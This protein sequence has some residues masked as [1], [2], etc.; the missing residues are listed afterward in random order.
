MKISKINILFLILFFLNPIQAEEEQTT[1]YQFKHNYFME[2]LL[3]G[4]NFYKKDQNGWGTFFLVM[5]LSSLYGVY[6]FHNRFVKYNSLYKSA[7]LADLYYGLGYSYF[8][9]VDGGF[10][11]TKEFFIQSGRS[12]SFRNL[13][14]GVQFIFTIIGIYKG[15]M[16]S[17]EEYENNAPIYSNLQMNF[18]HNF[19]EKNLTIQYVIPL[20]F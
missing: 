19:L 14:L 1:N 4:Y 13:S 15:Y 8:D 9:P 5:R 17:W 16:D 18:N 7:K 20:D 2:I 11:N 3:P 6:Y 12:E 10:K